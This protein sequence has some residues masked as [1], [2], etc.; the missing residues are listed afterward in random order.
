MHGRQVV[1]EYL[2][3]SFE[4]TQN[5]EA[6]V[7]KKDLKM[8]LIN[9]GEP[10]FQAG[11]KNENVCPSAKVSDAFWPGGRIVQTTQAAFLQAISP[12]LDL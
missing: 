2:S 6:L 5:I 8:P 11:R 7:T 10:S 12:F 3:E 4:R 1:T 9:A